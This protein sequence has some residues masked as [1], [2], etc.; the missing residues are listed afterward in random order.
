MLACA[1]RF[2]GV[3][4]LRETTTQ[5]HG[6]IED[7]LFVIGR[8]MIDRMNLN[9]DMIRWSLVEKRLQADILAETTWRPQLRFS[10]SWWPS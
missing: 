7:D 5:L 9:K 2:C 1:Q 4:E 6:K 3:G 8:M 10:R